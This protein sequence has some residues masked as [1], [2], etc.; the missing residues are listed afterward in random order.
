MEKTINAKT[1]KKRPATKEEK[2]W[3]NFKKLCGALKGKIHYD[4]SVFN[5]A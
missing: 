1:T 4:D 5:L 3:E 2:N